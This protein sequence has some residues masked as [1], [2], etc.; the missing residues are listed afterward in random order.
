VDE[1]LAVYREVIERRA[2]LPSNYAVWQARVPARERSVASP[3]DKR[4]RSSA[5]IM[6]E[7]IVS[8]PGP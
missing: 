1:I 7:D 8:G 6:R 5:Q 2:R 4:P 3:E